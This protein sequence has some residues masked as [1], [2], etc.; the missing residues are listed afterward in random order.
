MMKCPN[1]NT[2]NPAD[3]KFCFNCGLS[4]KIDPTCANCGFTNEQGAKFC[5]NCGKPLG[6]GGKRKKALK[7]RSNGKSKLPFKPIWLIL[8]SVALLI[9]LFLVLVLRTPKAC[10]PLN[11]ALD[12]NE[13]FTYGCDQSS[14]Y[15]WLLNMEELTDTE[16]VY[17]WGEAE[18]KRGPCTPDPDPSKGL[19][20]AFDLP[21]GEVYDLQLSFAQDICTIYFSD[22]SGLDIEQ[23]LPDPNALPVFS[24]DPEEC[25]DF[26]NAADNS[27]GSLNLTYNP[28]GINLNPFLIN[29]PN[30]SLRYR[31]S[32][33]ASGIVDCVQ[34]K[35]GAFSCD[36]PAEMGETKV[37]FWL[38]DGTCE[39]QLYSPDESAL[40]WSI[41]GYNNCSPDFIE[42]LK[43]GQDQWYFTYKPDDVLADLFTLWIP[44]IT[45][46][47]DITI[48]YKIDDDTEFVP[49]D[50]CII[51][52]SGQSGMPELGCYIMLEEIPESTIRYT[53]MNGDCQFFLGWTSTQEIQT[54]LEAN[55]GQ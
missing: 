53:I 28:I 50:R 46:F 41:N 11:D 3:S 22:I 24:N 2:E 16:V 7:Q 42:P 51:K 1:C 10:R 30:L 43:N 29:L 54:Y 6:A 20:C 40:D 44:G 48:L 39:S 21:E 5:A 27:L 52:E 13:E 34:L 8:G 33:G 38:N 19:R 12:T 55:P 31:W 9:I 36:F 47:E 26:Q 17:Q 45:K 14:C 37:D 4:L 25:G 18:E 35:E 49:A 32:N 23:I 15:I